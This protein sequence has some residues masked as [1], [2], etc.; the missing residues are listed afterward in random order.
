M[1]SAILPAYASIGIHADH[2]SLTKFGSSDDPGF[3]S[4]EAEL[5]RIVK[6]ARSEN[7]KTVKGSK[8]TALGETIEPPVEKAGGGGSVPAHIGDNFQ[9]NAL[10]GGSQTFQGDV[11]FGP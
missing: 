10:Y 11:R 8:D 6:K 7:T 9:S 2:I 3:V 1:D 4:V 5:R